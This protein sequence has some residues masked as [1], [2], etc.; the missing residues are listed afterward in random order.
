MLTGRCNCAA[1]CFE[2]DALVT[3]VYV[4]HCSICRRA[5]GANGIPVLVVPNERLRFVRG[6][7]QVVSW[8]KADGDWERSFCR[9]CGSPLPHSNGPDTTYV[10]A[11][12]LDEG[13]AALRVAHHL[14]V[15]SKATWDE[16]GDGG[17]QHT[18]QRPG[19][20]GLVG[21]QHAADAADGRRLPGDG[22]DAGAEDQHVGRADAELGA[23]GERAGGAGVERV[24]VVLGDDEELAHG[25]D[26]GCGSGGCGRT[27]GVGMRLSRARRARAACR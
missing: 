19:E 16:I 8:R 13:A 11:G 5:T 6:R 10:P 1:V 12:T 20:A 23:A 25:D 3:D 15:G 4:C 2:I 9:V 18:G 14:W 21:G 24:A 22:V 17:R 26:L 7:E 27:G